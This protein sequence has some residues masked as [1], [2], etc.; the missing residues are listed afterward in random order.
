M[1]TP[2]AVEMSGLISASLPALGQVLPSQLHVRRIDEQL[3]LALHVGHRLVGKRSEDRR[4]V[5]A[6]P[7][8]RE[9]RQRVVE[10]VANR[11]LLDGRDVLA[12]FEAR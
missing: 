5:R 6:T 7:H 1:M 2:P 9:A 10:D 12:R 4:V 3:E 11:A 8:A